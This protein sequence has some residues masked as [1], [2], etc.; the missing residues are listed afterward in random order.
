[1]YP[2]C[3]CHLDSQD[4]S[5]QCPEVRKEIDCTGGIREIYGEGIRKEK[6][7]TVI[8]IIDFRRSKIGNG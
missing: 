8:N 5:L 7:Q 4:L 3:K 2:V 6:V 1:M